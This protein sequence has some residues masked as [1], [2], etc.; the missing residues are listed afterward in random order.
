MTSQTCSLTSMNIYYAE[1]RT[2]S[3]SLVLLHLWWESLCPALA[4]Y[5][6]QK[7]QCRNAL[8]VHSHGTLHLWICFIN[9]CCWVILLVVKLLLRSCLTTSSL[10]TKMQ[11]I[12]GNPPTHVSVS[13]G[14]SQFSCRGHLVNHPTHPKHFNEFKISF[15][16]LLLTR[17]PPRTNLRKGIA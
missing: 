5:Y 1:E 11:V 6:C 9:N 10:G 3:S 8:I 7:L 17:N 13:Y 2:A 12:Y 15:N 16:S 4:I 14:G